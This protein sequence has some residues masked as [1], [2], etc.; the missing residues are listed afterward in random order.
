M[1]LSHILPAPLLMSA[2]AFTLVLSTALSVLFSLES[3][4]YATFWPVPGVLLGLYLLAGR[5]LWPALTAV[6]ISTVFIVNLLFVGLNP[7]S[8]VAF[9]VVD[10]FFA[11]VAAIVL[12]DRLKLGME[13]LEGRDV[14]GLGVLV[15]LVCMGVNAAVSVWIAYPT[16]SGRYLEEL[17]FT[18]WLALGLGVL[19][20]TPLVMT[21]A[22]PFAVDLPWTSTV[23]R[24]EIIVMSIYLAI[25]CRIMFFPFPSGFQLHNQTTLFIPFLLWAA[26]RLGPRGISVALLFVN[27]TLVGFTRLGFGPLATA[28]Q[29]PFERIVS[30]QL[31][32][33]VGSLCFLTLSILFNQQKS[34][35]LKFS[36]LFGHAPMGMFA[37]DAHGRVRFTNRRW[38]Q[39]T[40][41]S[42]DGALGN[43][44]LSV[45]HPLDLKRVHSHWKA[46]V[47]QQRPFESEFRLEAR[48][49]RRRAKWVRAWADPVLNPRGRVLGYV[50]I[51]EDLTDQKLNAHALK[52]RE[53]QLG[54]LLD[55]TPLLVF[56]KDVQGKFTYCNH[57]CLAFFGK[58]REDVL[59]HTAQEIHPLNAP[60]HAIEHDLQVRV[61][62]DAMTFEE[63]IDDSEGER[64]TFLA[65]KFPLQGVDGGEPE[66][67]CIATDI[68]QMKQFEREREKLHVRERDARVLAESINRSK[69]EFIATLSH[70]LRT[71]MNSI[72]GWTELILSGL[73]RQEELFEV[74][75]IIER[76]ARTEAQLIEELLDMSTIVTGKFQLD[77]SVASFNDLVAESVE[78]VHPA[79][80]A[81]GILVTFEPR[82]VPDVVW[83]DA[84]RMRQV[85][86]NLLN[87][88]V[89]FTSMEGRVDVTTFN[90][91][92]G[93]S[94]RIG[95]RVSDT[96][97]GI[98]A[99]YIARVF[100]PFSQE[101]S[102]ISRKY[103]GLG[104]GL[105]IVKSIVE[106]H[107]G[108]VSVTSAGEGQGAVFEFL[109]PAA[110]ET[111]IE[112]AAS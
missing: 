33:A 104:L 62:G 16:V 98:K 46:C 66:L 61:R 84:L 55:N 72:L 36:T 83:V 28:H 34:R 40:S 93:G 99:D 67:C 58:R 95:L 8:A 35:D 102:S 74:V 49:G 9:P 91:R 87:N 90:I 43:G 12:R 24:F 6:G 37:A 39:L 5:T 68:T 32:L 81:R 57:V 79:A 30:T 108:S 70:E 50:G 23:R 59:G 80:T 45:I 112:Q 11:M 48:S 69:D 51:W 65:V 41:T 18:W 64:H 25:A 20:F 4:L 10:A 75:G 17:F 82:A 63:T 110:Q 14:F 15:A 94:D 3:H 73:V 13:F 100:E 38:T 1:G 101:D 88:A 77:C 103:G 21:W 105:S 92:S 71:P 19:V 26:L 85:I 54:A 56:I 7:F 76:C 60:D 86:W 29:T 52:V 27:F 89:K 97:M 111:S 2:T 109:L 78:M 31:F 42:M 22:R 96:G 53:A 44:W 47:R 107:S 106:L